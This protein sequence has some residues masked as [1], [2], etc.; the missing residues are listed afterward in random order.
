MMTYSYPLSRPFIS[1]FPN[2]LTNIIT[3]DHP[4][5]EAFPQPWTFSPERWLGDL[6]RHSHQFAFGYG[7]RMCVASHLA[8]NLVYTVLLHLIQHFE[9][10]LATDDLNY[11][12][13]TI[14]PIRGLSDPTTLTATPIKHI[15]RFVPR[16][17]KA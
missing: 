5:P 13:E 15:A 4:D 9:I 17:E 3:S 12:N 2:I 14:D 8:F 6:G 16:E 7:S 10:K 11:D 1:I